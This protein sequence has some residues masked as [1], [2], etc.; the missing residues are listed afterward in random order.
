MVELVQSAKVVGFWL[1]EM[2]TV[3]VAAACSLLKTTK[4]SPKGK[5][6]LGPTLLNPPV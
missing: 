2:S 4:A 3:M 6:F 1:K 5:V